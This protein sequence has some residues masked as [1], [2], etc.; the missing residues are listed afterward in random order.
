[1][2]ETG[3]PQT[4]MNVVVNADAAGAEAAVREAWGGPLCVVERE[5]RPDRELRAIRA[6]AE[7]YLDELGIRWTWSQDGDVG[8]AAEVGVIADPD[9]AAQAALDA[10]Y[11]RGMVRLF[12]ALRPVAGSR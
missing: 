12:P 2:E 4:I 8:L 7:R 3:L 9:G 5:V 11:G 1:M 6:E 10:R